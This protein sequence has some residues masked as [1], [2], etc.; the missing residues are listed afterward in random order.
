M[1]SKFGLASQRW[2]DRPVG[3][4]IFDI[5]VWL[6]ALVGFGVVGAWGFYQ[7]GFTKDRGAQDRNYRYML[8]VDEMKALQDST[9]TQQQVNERWMRQYVKLAVFSKFYPTNA[10]LITQ[11]AQFGH[12]PMHVDRMLAACSMY[13]DD[14]SEYNDLLRKVESVLN[15]QPQREAG[16]VIPWMADVEWQAL[17]EA[18]VR[19]KALIIE[20]G[21]LTGVEPRLIV[22]C[23]I[24]EQIRLFNS[25]R[26]QL[27]KFLGPVKV[28]NVQ[29]QFSYGVNGIKI[30]TAKAIEE[31][32]K[33]PASPFYMGKRYEHLLDY[34]VE[35]TAQD[36]ERYNRL[37]DYRNHLYSYLYTA[38]ILHQ[39]MLQWRRAGY[40]I[41]NRPDI[42]FTLFN[43]G[44]AQSIPKPDPVCGGSHIKVGDR[45]YTFG[46]IGFDFYF[47]GEL[48][49]DFPFWREHFIPGDRELTEEELDYIQG[50]VSN[51]KR[52]PRGWEYRKAD[53]TQAAQQPIVVYVA[54]EEDDYAGTY[55][56][57]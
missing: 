4:K 45:M 35:G 28:L 5:I 54:D 30:S 41:S 14:M 6:F 34:T 21:R 18:I 46:A 11:A 9:L 26:E 36:D 25:N 3:R 48:A 19:D 42:L 55:A 23:L 10:Q 15:D 56:N 49:E 17:R 44:F 22:G 13:I 27:K 39:T 57:E 2:R 1:A 7:L 12:D 29:S 31:H 52:P 24:G 32:L 47:S 38:C 20:A 33:D 8:S 43:V 37:V 40:D 50:S 16:T 53:S 51:C